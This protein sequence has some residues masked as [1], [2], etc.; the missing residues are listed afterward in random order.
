MCP[1]PDDERTEGVL[2]A[3]E[4]TLARISHSLTC[5]AA[6][7]SDEELL[8]VFR[9]ILEARERAKSPEAPPPN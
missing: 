1:A 6:E 9:A 7:L 4:R 3:R 2:I 5:L 8:R